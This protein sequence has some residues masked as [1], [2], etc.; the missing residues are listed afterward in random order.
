MDYIAHE[1]TLLD[2]ESW[3]F[4][5]YAA[6]GV[7]DSPN[8]VPRLEITATRYPWNA[9]AEMR[10]RAVAL[11][12]PHENLRRMRPADVLPEIRTGRL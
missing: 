12:E 1:G 5:Q 7:D 6:F 9:L 2:A 4:Q 3:Y 8:D 10:K 11:A